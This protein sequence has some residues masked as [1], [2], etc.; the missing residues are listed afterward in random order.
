MEDLST[1]GDR[2]LSVLPDGKQGRWCVTIHGTDSDGVPDRDNFVVLYRSPSEED[3]AYISSAIASVLS[4]IIVY[5][6][7]VI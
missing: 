2:W 6:G 7:G 3:A 4:D 1:S 5:E